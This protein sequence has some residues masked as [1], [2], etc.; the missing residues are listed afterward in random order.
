MNI[1]I[2]SN[3]K[4]HPEKIAYMFLMAWVLIPVVI[5]FYD[6]LSALAGRFDAASG[7]DIIALLQ[8]LNVHRAVYNAAFFTF[9]YFTLLFAVWLVISYRKRFFN[10]A[11]IKE[12]PWVFLLLLLFLWCLLSTCFADDIKVAF[13]GKKYAFIG[14]RAYFIY[15]AMFMSALTIRKEKYRKNLLRLFCGVMT[16][17]SVL[18]LFQA[19]ANSIMDVSMGFDY[20]GVFFQHNHFGYVLCMGIIGSAGL[21]LFD[22]TGHFLNK[23]A[24]ICCMAVQLWGLLLNGTFGSYIAVLA[25][26]PVLY[27]FYFRSKGLFRIHVILPLIIFIL[28]TAVDFMGLIPADEPLAAR[29]GLLSK[30]VGEIAAGSEKVVHVGTG[31][32]T[33]WIQTLERIRQR[34]LF[35]FGPEGF[36]GENAIISH[37]GHTQDSPHNEFLQMAGYTGIPSL[38]FYLS[39]LGSLAVYNWK[40]LKKLDPVVIACSGVVVTY[41]VS[42]FFGNPISNTVVYFWMFLGLI[43][44]TGE[45]A[46]FPSKEDA[47]FPKKKDFKYQGFV[48]AAAGCA[49]ATGLMFA[50]SLLKDHEFMNEYA[51]LQAMRNAEATVKLMQ[52]NEN[53]GNEKDFWY[54]ANSFSL[55]PATEPAPSAYG[56]GSSL[57]GD[58]KDPFGQ[59]FPNNYNYDERSDYRD[60]IIKVHVEEIGDEQIIDMEWVPVDQ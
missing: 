3:K 10:A 9:G 33:L 5:S 19:Y 46:V 17:L 44:S 38:L 50:Y 8:R 59:L 21:F 16:Y 22:D 11:F 57:W 34:P 40:R 36:Y 30:E 7:A 23:S 27:L 55:F 32:G 4:I 43:A 47:Q 2:S 45:A 52:R 56:N 51:D 13:L 58:A 28:V 14:F 15:A 39:A 37:D 35:G 48:L 24:Y 12:N 49:L 1:S 29:F 60:M 42:S 53:L 31:R 26:L 25:G 41:L 20:S 54:D 6:I 18:I